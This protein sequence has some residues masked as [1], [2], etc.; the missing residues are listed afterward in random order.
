MFFRT[1]KKGPFAGIFLQ[2]NQNLTTRKKI[3]SLIDNAYEDQYM[4]VLILGGAGYIGSHMAKN[5]IDSGHIVTIADN[6]SSGFISATH[7][8]LFVKL[9]IQDTE[10]LNAL[11]SSQ[12][13]DAVM[14]F[15]SPIQVGESVID[16]E[17]YYRNLVSTL[18]LLKSMLNAKI[19]RIIFSSSAAVY[20]DPIYTP[21]N[22]SHSKHP[23]SPY[24]RSKW[25]AEQILEDFDRAYGLKSICLRY[26]N[27][28]GADPTGKLGERHDPETHL[29]PLVMQAASGRR[30]SIT[31]FGRDYDTPDGTCI[32][33]Y[34]HVSDLASAHALAL[35][36]LVDSNNSSV[37]NLGNGQGFSVQEVIDTA[38][39]IT[40]KTIIVTDEPR[41]VGDPPRL[42]ADSSKAHHILR[43]HPKYS[44]L[45]T[46]VN[47]AW[48]WEQQWPWI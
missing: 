3:L 48:H 15:A 1:E 39:R 16:P 34:I 21:I 11:F 41:R 26:F 8:S 46:I 44:D 30:K 13:F 9:D 45:D 43:W 29:I 22:E 40:G 37:F 14:H 42:V 19:M 24:G 28:S 33:D 32:R 35:E 5:L 7:G 10:S 36:C 31:V 25:M 4:N 17:K 20:G 6:L 23:I 47:H 27:A 12:K 2:Q 18:N 38:R